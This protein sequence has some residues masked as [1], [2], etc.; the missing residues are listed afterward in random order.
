MFGDS[1]DDADGLKA[2][3]LGFGE[4]PNQLQR[5]GIARHAAIAWQSFAIGQGLLLHQSH[6]SSAQLQSTD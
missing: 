3:T 1:F 2:R 6:D 4:S 5:V